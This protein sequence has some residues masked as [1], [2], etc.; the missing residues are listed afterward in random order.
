MQVNPVSRYH[1]P[2]AAIGRGRN[3]HDENTPR[4]NVICQSP[5]SIHRADGTEP[6]RTKVKSAPATADGKKQ[7][8]QWTFNYDATGKNVGPAPAQDLPPR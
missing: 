6:T 7:E 8:V 5:G 3:R 4:L 1:A 2:A